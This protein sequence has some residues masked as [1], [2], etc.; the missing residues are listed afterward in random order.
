[1]LG[2]FDM[3]YTIEEHNHR[4]AA[5]AASRAAS[6]KGCRFKVQ[7]GVT[8]LEVSGFT[9][10]FASPDQLP[11]PDE[12]DKRH[13]E[14]RG[15]IIKAANANALKFSHGVAAKLINCYLKVRFVC[16]GCHD[17]DRVKA[18]HPPIDDILLKQL[19]KIDFSGGTKH[20]RTY[21]QA[22][23]SKFDSGTYEE[24][25]NLIRSSLPAGEPLWKMEEYWGGYQ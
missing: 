8:I 17:N 9:P 12:I 20:W 23:W 18:L 3:A 21:R 5:W 15:Q 2:W 11:A 13:R 10:L 4:L 7:K 6:V 19:A 1:M 24:V 14:W 16:A 25:I 22:R